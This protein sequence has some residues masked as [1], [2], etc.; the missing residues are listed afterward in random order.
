MTITHIED[1]AE[2]NDFVELF[3]DAFGLEVTDL[4]GDCIT[5]APGDHML[6]PDLPHLPEDGFMAT[7]HRDVALARDDV[8]FLSWEHPFIDQALELILSG[9]AGN[10][11]VGYIEN[12]NYKTGDCF[13]QLQFTARC[14]A[15]RALQVERFLPPDAMHL[16]MTPTGDLKVNQPDLGEFVLSLKRGTARGLVEQKE[17]QVRPLISKLEKMGMGQL[18]KM[19]AR[20]SDRAT[21]AYE[22]RLGRL[23]ALSEQ[24]AAISGAM[25]EEVERE[26]AKVVEAISRS[27][28]VLDSVRL[29]FCG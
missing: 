6:V 10:A 13:I 11:A 18:D 28:L 22:D 29:V 4:G 19:I 16:T 15:P 7:T 26:K 14:P 3:A 23:R 2:L 21:E 20:A 8:Q 24:N 9:P 1:E 27:Q 5:I 17:A 25:I 12:H